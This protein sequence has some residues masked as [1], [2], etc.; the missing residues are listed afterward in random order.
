MEREISLREVLLSA[1]P[2]IEQSQADVIIEAGETQ[3]YSGGVTLC[4]EGEFE[5]TFFIVLSGEVEVSKQ[6]H[7]NE[8]RILKLLGPGSFFGEM[9]IIHSAPR[10]A[11]VTTTVETTVLVIHKGAFTGLLEHSKSISLAVIREV[12]QRLRENDE[13]AISDLRLKAQ[14]MAEAYQ[15]LAEEDFA[16]SQFLASVA[17][18]LRIPLITVNDLLNG[19]QTGIIPPDALPDVM[20]SLRRNLREVTSLINEILVLQEIDIITTGYSPI[21]LLKVIHK[22]IE[23]ETDMAGRNGVLIQLITGGSLPFIRGDEKSLQR[24]I[25]S[26]LD[27]A[28][29]FSPDGGEVIVSLNTQPQAVEIIIRDY[30]VGIPP[31]ALPKIFQ[32]FFHLDIISGRMFRGAGLGLSIARQVIEQHGGAIEVKSELGKGS[33]FTIQLP[34][35]A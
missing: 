11:T 8:K 5:Q 16:R 33:S 13:M 10:A 2:G 28:I 14:E 15:Q 6:L 20:G 18:N 23:Q 25:A 1:F 34:V 35:P 19:I 12:S 27:N 26:V 9:A 24:A 30:G 29:K 32:R 3:I 7:S 22:A 17:N 31:E 4:K 21:A